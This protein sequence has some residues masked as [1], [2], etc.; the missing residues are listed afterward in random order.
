MMNQEIKIFSKL[1]ILYAE[2]DEVQRESISKT[3]KLIFKNVFEAKDGEEA[4][5]FFKTQTPIDIVLLDYVMPH[6][7]GYEVA[8]FI[9]KHYL[10]IPV[11]IASAHSDKQKLLNAIKTG[12]VS[13]LEK[14]ITQEKLFESFSLA[15]KKLHQ[16]D[17]IEVALND[18]CRYHYLEKTFYTDTQFIKL[19]KNEWVLFELL[20]QHRGKLFTKEQIEQKVF[21]EIVSEN[22]VRNLVYRLRKKIGNNI[23]QTVPEVGY[24]IV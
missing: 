24:K 14:P 4:L 17:M 5:H 10:K 21:K 9:H 2:D 12:I 7:N 1:N 13:Y 15:L 16:Y 23:I 3:L 8:S 22:T 6:K 11:I 19:T 20:L 18:E